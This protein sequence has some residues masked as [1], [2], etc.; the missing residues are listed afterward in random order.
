[1][2]IV[3]A[4]KISNDPER[5][6]YFY[7]SI[8]PVRFQK[9]SKEYRF[10]KQVDTAERVAKMTGCLLVPRECLHWERKQAFEDRRIVIMRKVFYVLSPEMMT[11]TELEKYRSA[12]AVV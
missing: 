2:S 5:L 9:L 10:W 11:R 8:H 3:P 4:E 7:P 12:A 6:L 1:M